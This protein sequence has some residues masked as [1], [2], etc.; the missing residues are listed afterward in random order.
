LEAAPKTAKP[1]E[2]R[3][4]PV[5]REVTDSVA[6][7]AGDPRLTERTWVLITESP[8]GSWGINGF[9]KRRRRRGG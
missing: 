6:A 5:V 3:L 2:R 1:V 8:E 4:F 9:G 7:A